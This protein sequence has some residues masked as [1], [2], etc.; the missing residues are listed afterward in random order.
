VRARISASFSR[1][2]PSPDALATRVGDEIVLV[3]TRTDKIYVLNRT[4]A[5]VW[6]LIGAALD[7]HEVAGRLA[8]EF[9]ARPDEIG[10]E[11]DALIDALVEGR[12]LVGRH[13]D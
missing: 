3:H 7:R 1:F 12:L 9:Q 4:G 10:R 5:R 11:V 2:L 8:D 6:E 13:E